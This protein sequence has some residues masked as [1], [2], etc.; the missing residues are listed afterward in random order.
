MEMETQNEL[1]GYYPI[2]TPRR[3]F[4]DILF[5]MYAN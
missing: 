3:K 1:K 4:L 2:D 5:K